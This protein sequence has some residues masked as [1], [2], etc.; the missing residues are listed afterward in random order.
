MDHR[1]LLAACPLVQLDTMDGLLPALDLERLT[2]TTLGFGP[3]RVPA[4]RLPG[5]QAEAATCA[6]DAGLVAPG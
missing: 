3:D 2:R 5:R 4:Q 1:D 6:R